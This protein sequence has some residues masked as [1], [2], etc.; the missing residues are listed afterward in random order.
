KFWLNAT[1][2]TW[3]DV[4]KQLQIIAN[5]LCQFY[6]FS[7]CNRLPCEFIYSSTK[8]LVDIK[9]PKYGNVWRNKPNDTLEEFQCKRGYSLDLFNIDERNQSYPSIIADPFT[10][11]SNDFYVKVLHNRYR[12][13]NSMWGIQFNFESLSYYPWSGDRQKTKLF[14]VTFGY[15]RSV[16]DFVPPP[17]LMNYIDGIDQTSK[18][19]SLEQVMNNKKSVNSLQRKEL[20]WTNEQSNAKMNNSSHIQS[21]IL[22]MN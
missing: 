13:C 1:Q 12:S 4:P 14:D 9:C 15:D 11:I 22:W 7:P 21:P 17:W 20:F 19:L 5:A 2:I 3:C 16:Y 8:T 10:P 18:R 6:D